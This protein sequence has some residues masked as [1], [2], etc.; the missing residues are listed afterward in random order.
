[1][2]GIRVLDSLYTLIQFSAPVSPGSSGGAV[3][4]GAGQVVAIVVSQ[5]SSGQN[6]NFGIPANSVRRLLALREPR[7][8]A[9][10]SKM[11]DAA[12]V[13]NP[14]LE[15]PATRTLDP[16]FVDGIWNGVVANFSFGIKTELQVTLRIAGQNV[17]G[18]VLIARPLYGSGE[19]SGRIHGK[20]LHFRSAGEGHVIKWEAERSGSTLVGHYTVLE[21]GEV[22]T[23]WAIK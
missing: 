11:A 21:T 13:A 14:S 6:L 8:L 9:E 10:T 17:S 4:N 22:G 2:S 12:A 20:T 19:L 7:S 15:V 23:W 3:F 1:M 5:L 18:K 16:D